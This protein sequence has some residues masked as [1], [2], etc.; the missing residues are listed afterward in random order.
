[1]KDIVLE[2]EHCSLEFVRLETIPALVARAVEIVES[3]VVELK[4]ELNA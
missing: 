4:E 2:I 1:L 3:A